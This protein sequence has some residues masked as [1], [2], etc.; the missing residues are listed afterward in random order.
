MSLESV[1]LFLGHPHLAVDRSLDGSRR[2]R[3][4]Q[5]AMLGE[6][7]R[8]RLREIDEARLARAIRR[9]SAPAEDA[10]VGRDMHDPAALA[11][12]PRASASWL[13]RGMVMKRCG[14]HREAREAYEGHAVEKLRLGAKTTSSRLD[15][16][17]AFTGVGLLG[18]AQTGA[19][20]GYPT[21]PERQALRELMMI[22]LDVGIGEQTAKTPAPSARCATASIASS[23]RCQPTVRGTA[24]RPASQG[25]APLQLGGTL[26]PG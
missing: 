9:P 24:W 18:L 14:R 19:L 13:L 26:H 12:R 1:E 16:F 5:Y 15:A 6:L 10:G 22:T 25:A 17:L 11:L 20:L 8:H 21:E 4:D 7:D 2:D 3:I 23:G